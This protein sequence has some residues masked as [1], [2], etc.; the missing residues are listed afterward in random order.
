MRQDSI[1]TI[2]TYQYLLQLT[3]CAYHYISLSNNISRVNRIQEN[4]SNNTVTL[5][6]AKTP[7]GHRMLANA[8]P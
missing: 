7:Q 3:V 8:R 6:F 2:L 4:K 5:V 1:L